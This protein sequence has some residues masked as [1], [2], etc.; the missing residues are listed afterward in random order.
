MVFAF[1]RLIYL[2]V[3][4][5]ETQKKF[6]KQRILLLGLNNLI[7]EDEHVLLDGL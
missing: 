7:A 6:V 1:L 4:E 5:Q 3:N 2:W